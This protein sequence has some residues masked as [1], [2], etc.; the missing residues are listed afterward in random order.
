MITVHRPASR[1][2]YDA[3]QEDCSFCNF[4][5]SVFMFHAVTVRRFQ[6]RD[7]TFSFFQIGRTY[8][9]AVRDCERESSASMPSTLLE[10]SNKQIS[11]F[12]TSKIR[13]WEDEISKLGACAECMGYWIGGNDKNTEGRWVHWTLPILYFPHSSN[14]S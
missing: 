12:I 6:W 7:Y 3:N 11:D 10:I 1:C 9:D 14:L 5:M 4:I 2:M 13:S 8:G